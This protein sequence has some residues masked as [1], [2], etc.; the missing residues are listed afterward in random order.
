MRIL[1]IVFI[2]IFSPIHAGNQPI[3]INISTNHRHTVATTPQLPNLEQLHQV[4]QKA[5][6]YKWPIAAGL[7]GSTYLALIIYIQKA[8]WLIGNAQSWC[9]WHHNVPLEQLSKLEQDELYCQIKKT[10]EER[11]IDQKPNTL[12]QLARFFNETGDEIRTL[13][14]Y[15]HI[16]HMLT[17]WWLAKLFFI[18]NQSILA[19]HEGIR[20]LTFMRS[21]LA[22]ELEPH[23]TVRRMY[24]I[25]SP[26]LEYQV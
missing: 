15:T 6:E 12:M 3:I 2:I 16:T 9:N 22:T 19:A 13:Q 1:P 18:K 26:S 20:R 17:S 21:I 24:L 25:N 8:Q 7:V 10:F 14:R 5:Q 23:D 4:A 11:Y